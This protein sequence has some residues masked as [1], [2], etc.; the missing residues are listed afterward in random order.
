MLR[1]NMN[2]VVELNPVPVTPPAEKRI[3]GGWATAGLGA[4][5]LVVLFLVMVLI[6]VILAVIVTIMHM[7]TTFTVESFTDS[8]YAHMGL[9]VSVA[10]IVAY[11]AAAGLTLAFIKIRG[12]AGI[13]A[14]LGLKRIN[15]KMALV[16]VLI[17][18]VFLALSALVNYYFHVEENDTKT[19]VDIYNTSVWPVLLWIMV[20]VFA[21]IFEESLFRGFL[22]E[23]LRR[24]RLGLIG[25][26]V[27]TS[28]V[29]TILHAGYSVS[30]LGTIFIFGLVLG[31][32]RYKTGS[33][34]GT[35]LMH[36]LY[37]TVGMTLI[38]LN[39]G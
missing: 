3:W 14:Y 7:D 24:S 38:A 21:P 31:A 8:I 36:A 15:W 35:M 30:S 19:L 32:V 29:W 23:G 9:L 22:F 18:A 10:G 25:T 28:L 12:G 34:W 37:N 1:S 39:I 11:A 27:V 16:P 6:I 2:D 33:L 20:V 26:I 4:V 5:I 13:A 17:T